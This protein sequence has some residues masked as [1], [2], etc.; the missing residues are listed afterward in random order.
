MHVKYISE[1]SV[2]LGAARCTDLFV[3][4][5]FVM[6]NCFIVVCKY[7]SHVKNIKILTLLGLS[8]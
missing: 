3:S 8:L 6:L 1:A 2:V 4:N 5:V 7:S